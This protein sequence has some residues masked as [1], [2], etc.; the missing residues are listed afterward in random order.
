MTPRDGVKGSFLVPR[1][2]VKGPFLESKR[3]VPIDS[4]RNEIC[5]NMDVWTYLA[6]KPMVWRRR[7][8]VVLVSTGVGDICCTYINTCEE[9]N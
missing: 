2:G 8:Y 7:R 1:D 5:A 4:L 9:W 6:L 3:T